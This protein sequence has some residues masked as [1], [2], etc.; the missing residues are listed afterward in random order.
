MA[1]MYMGVGAIAKRCGVSVQAVQHWMLKHGPSGDGTFPEPKVKVTNMADE[2]MD[3]GVER[4]MTYGWT[5]TQ[6]EEIAA[7]YA[8]RPA[9]A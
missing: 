8:H 7:R 6:L 2:D 9:A 1:D 4:R 3:L 5:H